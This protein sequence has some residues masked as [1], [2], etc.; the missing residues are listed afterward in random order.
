MP[1]GVSNVIIQFH[2]SLQFLFCFQFCHMKL[3]PVALAISLLAIPGFAQASFSKG[4]PSNKLEIPIA[5]GPNDGLASRSVDHATV[6]MND[7][8]DIVVTYHAKREDLAGSGTIQQVEFAYFK[9]TT[10]DVWEHI[11]T[12]VIGSPIGDPL[13]ILI[14]GQ[15][16]AS[17]RPDVVAV[18]DK[19][20]IAWTRVYRTEL[21]YDDKEAA[22][23][24]CAWI[25]NDP[26]SGIKIYTDPIPITGKGF[27]LDAHDSSLGGRKFYAKDCRG[28]ADAVVL[29]G[30][31]N[32]TVGVVY[33]HQ[34]DFYATVPGDESRRFSLRMATCSIDPTTNALTAN[35][36]GGIVPPDLEQNLPFDGPENSAGMVLPDLAPSPADNSFWLI[37]EIQNWLNPAGIPEKDGAIKL[38]YYRLS[39]GNWTNLASKTFLTEPGETSRIRRRPMVS[40]Y[41]VG[42]VQQ[43]VSLSFNE[44]DL[45]PPTGGDGSSKVIY[46]HWLYSGGSI[47]PP[48][49]LAFFPNDKT[50]DSGKCVPLRGRDN[51]LI[52]RCYAD[53]SPTVGAPPDRIVAINDLTPN[54]RTV[55][56]SIPI[57]GTGSVGRPAAAYL[58]YQPQPSGT[59]TDYMVVTW[60]RRN[61]A[62]G[63]NLI[64]I[65]VE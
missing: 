38:G 21:A 46:R 10:G 48:P 60:E 42:A 17:V 14:A 55:I 26:I 6:A 51:P 43:G 41:P 20:F 29:N 35:P 39:G 57:G 1:N 36:I 44:K 16:S 15:Y 37:A 23:I 52:R 54:V 65:G 62:G 3:L 8:R 45:N 27:V 4:L 40:S 19:F 49:S 28:V 34:T 13:Q 50:I 63:Q 2:R 9:W 7:S 58:L 18:G 22:V 64:W 53:E 25:E 30:N 47:S 11:E 24:E 5:N 59:P 33:P 32:P 61:V 56:D 31:T 12:T